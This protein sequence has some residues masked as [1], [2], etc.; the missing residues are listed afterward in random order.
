MNAKRPHFIDRREAEIRRMEEASERRRQSALLRGALATTEE[1]AAEVDPQEAD[2]VAQFGYTTDGVSLIMAHLKCDPQHRAFV[3]AVIGLYRLNIRDADAEGFVEFNDRKLALRAGRSVRWVQDARNAFRD[4]PD[5]GALIEI[6]D[7]W[8][9]PETGESHAHA[10]RVHVDELGV[11]AALAAQSSPEWIRD[12]AHAMEEAAKMIGDSAPGFPPRRKKRRRGQSSADL[13]LSKLRQAVKQI[14]QAI[15]LLAMVHNPDYEQLDKLQSQLATTLQSL[16]ETTGLPI[17]TQDTNTNSVENGAPSVAAS[18]PP[19]E[20]EKR[21]VV[22]KFATTSDTM[23]STTCENTQDN[24]VPSPKAVADGSTV[25][26]D[27]DNGVP[28]TVTGDLGEGHVGWRDVS[29]AESAAG[30]QFDEISCPAGAGDTLPDEIYIPATVPNTLEA[31]AGCIG[32]QRGRPVNVSTTAHEPD[33]DA[34]EIRTP[35]EGG[36]SP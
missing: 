16:A 19:P 35:D 22:A 15:A 8:R 26:C 32:G 24:D 23:E 34:G 7:H 13:A 1:T 10:Y 31:L 3:D 33:T 30:A 11:E 5:H 27:A 14:E 18:A 17:S 12:P 21:G 6:K 4:W 36:K 9:D 20:V 29:I 28:V 2:L 25:W